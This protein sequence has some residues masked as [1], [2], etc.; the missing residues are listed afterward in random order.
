MFL[1]GLGMGCTTLPLNMTILAG[2][3]PQESGAAA[4]VLQTMQMVGGSLGL[5]ILVTVFGTASRG[6]AAGHESAHAVLAHGM[7]SAF[8][9]A[10]IFAACALVL[11][12]TVI[13][14]RPRIRS[15]D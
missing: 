5:A 15:A 10:T 3:R 9:V 14:G 6:A 8:T 7:G 11:V 12:T 2:V 13:R 1:A 4:G